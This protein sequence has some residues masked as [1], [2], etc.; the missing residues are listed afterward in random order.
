MSRFMVYIPSTQNPSYFGTGEV[1]NYR[2]TPSTTWDG[3][4]GSNSGGPGSP[5]IGGWGNFFFLSMEWNGYPFGY[6]FPELLNNVFFKKNC[7]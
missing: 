6:T 2:T 7:P 4:R 1:L 5:V 3:G